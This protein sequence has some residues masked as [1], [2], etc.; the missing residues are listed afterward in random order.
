MPSPV[1]S[2]FD[3]LFPKTLFTTATRLRATNRLVIVSEIL[4]YEQKL[5]PKNDT[6]LCMWLLISVVV[7]SIVPST[8]VVRSNV[9][10]IYREEDRQFASSG[11]SV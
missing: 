11:R 9:L 1:F 10:P 7:R 8:D 3:L 5:T 2:N 6:S 4:Q